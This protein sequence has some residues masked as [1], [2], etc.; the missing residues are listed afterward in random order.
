ML[1][2]VLRS[3]ENSP[4]QNF[5]CFAVDT[6][7]SIPGRVGWHRVNLLQ[8]IKKDLKQHYIK[9]S[10]YGNVIKLRELAWNRNAWRD[11]QA[12]NLSDVINGCFELLM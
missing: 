5:S 2:H 1:R 3:P 7:N 4:T 12:S 9:L 11:V 6:L 10:S 8:D